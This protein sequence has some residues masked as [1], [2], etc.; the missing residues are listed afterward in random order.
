MQFNPYFLEI[1]AAAGDPNYPAL[2][3]GDLTFYPECKILGTR[4]P[5]KPAGSP[6]MQG[7]EYIPG[8][9]DLGDA[10][11]RALAIVCANPNRYGFAAFPTRDQAAFLLRSSNEWFRLHLWMREGLAHFNMLY[12]FMKGT[13]E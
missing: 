1:P 11:Y 6:W 3:Q 5:C 9:I 10:L 12:D 4:L 7:L 8:D 13:W 2:L